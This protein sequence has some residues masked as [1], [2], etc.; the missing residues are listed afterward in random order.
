VR[1]I[2]ANGVGRDG[3]RFTLRL[4][5]TLIDPDR[6]PA[7]TL[8]RH[9][10]ERWEHELYY[11]ELKLDVRNS[12]V[13]ASYTVEAALQ[14][15]AALAGGRL[16]PVPPFADETPAGIDWLSQ[17]LTWSWPTHLLCTLGCPLKRVNSR[18]GATP[19]RGRSHGRPLLWTSH[20]MED[21]SEPSW[22]LSAMRGI[23]PPAWKVLTPYRLSYC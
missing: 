9:Y 7:D 8:A 3:K 22:R 12:P 14:E 4:W 1:E 5:T 16:A 21:T 6:F 17:T 18:T 20:G 15:I 19:I 23:G 13:L 10:A 2:R 11:R